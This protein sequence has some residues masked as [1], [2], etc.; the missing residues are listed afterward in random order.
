M[1][2][3]VESLESLQDLPESWEGILF[4]SSEAAVT[5]YEAPKEIVSDCL[6][7]NSSEN[8]ENVHAKGRKKLGNGR[9][10]SEPPLV[11]FSQ[12][13]PSPESDRHEPSRRS[14]DHDRILRP[15]ASRIPT[16]TEL[17][18]IAAP[19]EKGA[20]VY[21][22]YNHT[23]AYRLSRWTTRESFQYLYARPWQ[24]V[25]DFYADLV[26]SGNGAS[27]LR[28]LFPSEVRV[29][30]DTWRKDVKCEDIKDTINEAVPGKLRALHV[31]EVGFY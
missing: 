21:F 26:G 5:L 14:I 8:G 11:E 19:M 15:P 25:V 18:R 3:V 28:R 22:H 24:K 10:N 2:Q 13:S 7:K 27:T 4:Q 30:L 23:D 12:N 1:N 20:K 9:S 6:E 16:S 31:A 17:G 29:I